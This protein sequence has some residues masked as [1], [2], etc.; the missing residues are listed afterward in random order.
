MKRLII[1]GL[2]GLFAIRLFAQDISVESF[3]LLENDLTAITNGTQEIDQ[4]GEVAALIKVVTTQQDFNFDIGSLGV[5]KVLQQ[6]GE[7]WVYVP[8]G[9][10]R[11]TISHQQLGLLRDYYF[12]IPILSAR[13]Y[14]L[15]LTTG[16]VVTTIKRPNNTQY[17]TMH[18]TPA[19]ASVY[20]DNTLRPLND[21]GELFQLLTVGKHNY[22]VEAVGYKSEVGVITITSSEKNSLDISLKSVMATLTVNCQDKEADIVINEEVKGRETWTGTLVPGIYVIEGRRENHR[23]SYE[24]VRLDESATQIVT[25]S[26]PSP[27]Y[28]SLR[29]ESNPMKATVFI[30]GTSYDETPCLIDE[31]KKVLIG[32]HKIELKKNGYKTFSTRVTLKQDEEFRLSNITLSPSV[33]GNIAAQF[34]PDKRAFPKTFLYADVYGQL[35]SLPSAGMSLGTFVSR[36]NIE[37]SAG[38]AFGKEKTSFYAYRRDAMA[39]TPAEAYLTRGFTGSL[40]MGYGFS[41]HPYLLLTPQ[42]GLQNL[43]VSGMSADLSE[44][45]FRSSVSSLLLS[46]RADYALMGKVMLTF[47]PSY[48]LPFRCGESVTTLRSTIPELR[49]G[50]GFSLRAGIGIRF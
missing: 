1:I 14:E 44:P 42:A 43:S 18:V 50:G 29:V 3:R 45:L 16:Q 11:I 26:P 12:P 24:E 40:L 47:S 34:S 2:L 31:T 6:V 22:R 8:R 36:V 38:Y 17:L 15:K 49:P 10:Q 30:D 27:I 23:N 4:N 13:T 48:A 35:G 5:V 7:I 21:A 33:S 20:I 46:L 25:L 37:A 19:T 9:A 28:G 41:A 32:E 39:E